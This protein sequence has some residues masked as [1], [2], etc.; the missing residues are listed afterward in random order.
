[1]IYLIYVFAIMGFAFT[2]TT[3]Y[4]TTKKKLRLIKEEYLVR[5]FIK[6]VKEKYPDII[7]E[8]SYDKYEGEWF[9]RHDY[10]ETYEDIEFCE[11]IGGLMSPIYDKKFFNW[12][13][14]YDYDRFEK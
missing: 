13:F 1:M 3:I 11:Y 7:V 2:S 8:Y 9:I 6:K 10:V 12:S 4:K 14:G 5:G